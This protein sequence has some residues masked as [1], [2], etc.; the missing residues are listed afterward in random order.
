ML[1][2]NTT[3]KKDLGNETEKIFKNGCRIPTKIFV[4]HR[5]VWSLV[6]CIVV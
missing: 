2:S 5:N 3:R 1:L 4:N 6:G